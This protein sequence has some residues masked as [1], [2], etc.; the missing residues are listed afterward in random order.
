MIG[1]LSRNSKAGEKIKTGSAEAGIQKPSLRAEP[2]SHACLDVS[3]GMPQSCTNPVFGTLPVVI[4]RRKTSSWDMAGHVPT[5][6]LGQLH[7]SFPDFIQ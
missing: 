7:L 4:V 6:S 2:D 3:A 1:R 5:A